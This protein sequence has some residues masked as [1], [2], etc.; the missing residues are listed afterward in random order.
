MKA[1]LIALILC[2]NAQADGVDDPNFYR[3][4]NPANP[5]KKYQFFA[6]P[7]WKAN[8]WHHGNVQPLPTR[9]VYSWDNC[10][11]APAQIPE[12]R[13]TA[14]LM[15]AAINFFLYRKIRK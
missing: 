6:P 2:T 14:L 13:I 4:F 15:L 5:D 7:A 1:L 12:P 10:N 3:D 8:Q 11:Q 9:C